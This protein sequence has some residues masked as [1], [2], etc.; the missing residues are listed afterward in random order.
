MYCAT[1]YDKKTLQRQPTKANQKY[2]KRQSKNKQRQS[3]NITKNEG[4]I[5]RD[6]TSGATLL[7]AKGALEPWFP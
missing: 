3:K 2:N 5:I 1:F 7:G 6:S 4:R